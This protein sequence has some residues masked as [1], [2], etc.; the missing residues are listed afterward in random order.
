MNLGVKKMAIPKNRRKRL[1]RAIPTHGI[2][3]A[4][5]AVPQIRLWRITGRMIIGAR[6]KLVEPQRIPAKFPH[7][8]NILLQKRLL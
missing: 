8:I 5:P 3:V 2:S 7:I 4:V 6:P 1:R